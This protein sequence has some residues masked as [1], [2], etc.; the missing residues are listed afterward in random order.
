MTGMG[1]LSILRKISFALLA[2]GLA[3][4]LGQGAH[5]A[6]V[7][8]RD[9]ALGAGA[10]DDQRTNRV[11]VQPVDCGLEVAEDLAVESI[12]CLLTVDGEDGIALLVLYL[13]K[14]MVGLSFVF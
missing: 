6:D 8:A 10:G 14:A 1:R 4:R 7:G 5:L 13:Y 11:E 9:K 12:E 2:E 3:L